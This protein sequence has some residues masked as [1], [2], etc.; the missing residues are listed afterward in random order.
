MTWSVLG[1]FALSSLILALAPGPDNIFVL[2]Q[3][4]LYGVKKGILVICGL[5]LGI[6]VQTLCVIVGVTAFI[7]AIPILLTLIKFAGA[8]YLL[9]LAFMA[10]THARAVAHIDLSGSLSQKLSP[11]LLTASRLIRRGLIMNLTNPK[12]QLFFLSF[13][14][15]FLPQGISGWPLM[16]YM[17]L[18]GAIFAT[19]TIIVFC[20]IAVFSGSLKH[21]F[22]SPRF[23]QCL[24][25]GAALIFTGLALYTIYSALQD[26]IL[27]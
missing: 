7:S 27:R 15:Q 18:L 11:E 23:N 19:A 26:S 1:S 12:V 5:C 25:Y 16:G 24:N 14:P 22:E 10:V 9:Y 4:A 17:A 13:F 20:A 21:K 2:T 8:A 6:L 3:S